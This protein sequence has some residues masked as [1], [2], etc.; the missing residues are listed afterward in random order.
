TPDSPPETFQT[1]GSTLEFAAGHGGELGT[2]I[3][4]EARH[5]CDAAVPDAS[6]TAIAVVVV[7]AL[8]GRRAFRDAWAGA[9]HRAGSG[10]AVPME[11]IEPLG[12]ACTA[13][14]G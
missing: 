5:A 6:L 10:H 9:G 12:E 8:L 3:A 13:A 2:Q 11:R 1:L 7:A 4:G 14:C